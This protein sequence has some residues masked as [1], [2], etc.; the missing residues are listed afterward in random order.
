MNSLITNENFNK[1]LILFWTLWWLV[2]FWTDIVGGLA[3]LNLIHANW[4][5]DR[6]YPFLVDSLKMY[7]VPPWVPL[8]LFIG[9]LICSMLS[10]LAFCWASLSI[11]NKSATWLRRAQIAYIISLVYWLAYFTADQIIMKYD[12]EENHMVQGGFELLCFFALYLLPSEKKIST[13]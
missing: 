7:L 13:N 5:P 12:L 4:T 10:S 1:I 3:H 2:A 9:I 6:N 11:I 8:F